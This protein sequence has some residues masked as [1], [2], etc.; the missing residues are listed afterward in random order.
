MCDIL[1]IWDLW[2][3]WDLWDICY[4]SGIW[5]LCYVSGI[6]DICYVSDIW[7]ICDIYGISCITQ[8]TPQPQPHTTY[9]NLR[10][11]GGEVLHDPQHRAEQS[12]AG[13]PG[14]L[15]VKHNQGAEAAQLFKAIGVDEQR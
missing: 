9:I 4:V 2:D 15:P 10:L 8:H 12:T 11:P 14:E 6:C 13:Q 3:F 5:D 1:G 7:D